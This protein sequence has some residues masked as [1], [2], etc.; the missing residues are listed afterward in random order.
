MHLPSLRFIDR[1]APDAEGKL[2]GRERPTPF[3]KGQKRE[4]LG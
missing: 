3:V 4:G 2:G 1:D